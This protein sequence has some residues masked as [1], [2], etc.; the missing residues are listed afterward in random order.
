MYIYIYIFAF[1]L[2]NIMYLKLP[3][4]IIYVLLVCY[5]TLCINITYL[6][7]TNDYMSCQ[8]GQ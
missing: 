3:K 5:L 6:N 4:I 7:F 1:L 2:P 8:E